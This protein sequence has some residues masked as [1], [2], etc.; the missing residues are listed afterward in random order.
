MTGSITW[1]KEQFIIVTKKISEMYYEMF[2]EIRWERC[3]KLAAI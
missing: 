1:N 2:A 3:E